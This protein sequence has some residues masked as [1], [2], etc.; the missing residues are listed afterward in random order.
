MRFVPL[1]IFIILILPACA[2]AQSGAKPVSICKG[3]SL[4]LMA[5]SSNAN[6]YEWHKNGE[7]VSGQ[8]GK[9]LTVSDEGNYTVF[10]LNLE[11]CSSGVSMAIQ[12]TYNVPIAVDDRISG[13][14]NELLLLDVL[15]ND[16]SLC[17]ALDTTTMVVVRLPAHGLVF[18]KNGK[19]LFKPNSGYEGLDTFTYSVTDKNGQGTNVATV[20]VDLT[21]PPLPVTLISFDAIKEGL[22]SLL[23]WL[24]SAELDSDHFEIERSTDAKNWIQLGKVAAVG[25]GN[26]NNKYNFVDSIPESGMNY[27]RLKM[28]DLDGTFAYSRIK[29]VNFPEFSWAKL[30]PNPVNDVLQIVINNR[31]VRKIRLID[32]YGRVMF[33]GQVSSASMRIDMKSYVPGTYLIHLEQEDGM[34]RVFKIVHLN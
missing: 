34:V 1:F 21:T 18:K 17:A 4:R 25:N 3:T 13:Q 10:A 7:I 28:I 2:F 31:R 27:Y 22:A 5:E 29:S 6:S 32:S 16:Q 12:L 20:T 33:D 11:G 8:T 19:F 9:E 23:T 26:A 24:T 30:Y 14:N 15:Q